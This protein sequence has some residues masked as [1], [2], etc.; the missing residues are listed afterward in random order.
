ME[1]TQNSLAPPVAGSIPMKT[2]SGLIGGSRADSSNSPSSVSAV[3]GKNFMMPP[4]PPPLRSSCAAVSLSEPYSAMMFLSL[5]ASCHGGRSPR[6]CSH[7]VSS[8]AAMHR[9]HAP[10]IRKNSKNGIPFLS[11]RLTSSSQLSAMLRFRVEI[12]IIPTSEICSSGKMT[13]RSSLI[14]M[15]AISSHMI[16]SFAP[17]PRRACRTVSRRGWGRKS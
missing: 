17:V 10:R 9:V 3:S 16:R 2:H 5:S 7:F 1:I 11:F 14:C 15:N 4:P 12:P 8:P 6:M 13:S